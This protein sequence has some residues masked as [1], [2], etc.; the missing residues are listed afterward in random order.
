MSTDDSRRKFLQKSGLGIGWLAALDLFERS[1]AAANTRNPL[2]PKSPP[3][4]ATAKS[5]DRKSVV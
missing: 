4:R 3:L 5:V 2:A 1:A